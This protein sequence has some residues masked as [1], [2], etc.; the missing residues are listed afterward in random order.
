[1]KNIFGVRTHHMYGSIGL[2]FVRVVMG[3]AFLFHGWGKIQSPFSWMGPDSTMPGLLQFL[4][5]FS[6]FGGGI[7]LIAGFLTPLACL[8]IA[9]TMIGAVYTHAIVMGDPFVGTSSYELALVYFSLSV[10]FIT[11]GPG[12]FSLDRIVFGRKS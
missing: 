2:L 4:A 3:V 10:L 6:E 9:F 1:M 7:A 12:Y 5:A 11:Q 8:G